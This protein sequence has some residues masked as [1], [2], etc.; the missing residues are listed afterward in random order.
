M[1][2]FAG[3]L[4]AQFKRL[5]EKVPGHYDHNMLKEHLFHEMHQQLKD[6]IQF[7]ISEKK[8][9]MKSFSKKL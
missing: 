8:L 4:E 6:S 2:Q 9:P 3:R 7:F 5:K 1:R